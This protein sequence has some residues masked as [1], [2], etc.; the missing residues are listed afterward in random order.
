MIIPKERGLSKDLGGEVVLREGTSGGDFSV[1]PDGNTGGTAL[2][3]GLGKD[4]TVGI[5]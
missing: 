1:P 5:S 2:R 3:G 4:L